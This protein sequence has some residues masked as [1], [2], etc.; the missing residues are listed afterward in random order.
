MKFVKNSRIKVTAAMMALAMG[1]SG[2]LSSAA[3]AE[4]AA[5]PNIAPLRSV[6]GQKFYVDKA[7]SVSDPKLVE[8]NEELQRPIMSLLGFVEKIVDRQSPEESQKRPHSAA[9][10]TCVSGLLE[11]WARAGALTDVPANTQGRVERVLYAVGLT[12]VALKLE[13]AGIPVGRQTKQWL[14]KLNGLVREDYKNFLNNNIYFWSGA[15]SAAVAL[16]A[17]D[18]RARSYQG[19]V[20][21]QAMRAISDTGTLSAELDRGKRALIYHQY[22]LSALLTLREAREA[23]GIKTSKQ[24]NDRL[25]LLADMVG[26]ALCNPAALGNAAKEPAQ[27][28]PGDWGFRAISVIGADLT[29]PDWVK[30]GI[31]PPHVNDPKMGGN[32]SRTK[33]AFQAAA[34]R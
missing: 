34:R 7:G 22:A 30:C 28:K 17:G 10:T 14:V 31:K 11:S 19:A 23:L 15:G 18:H 32:W 24:D 29:G 26:G 2:P 27:E 33:E 5:C 16:L 25:R 9:E 8:A 6:T 3:H 1:A 21:R 13:A 12:V 4:P 20:W